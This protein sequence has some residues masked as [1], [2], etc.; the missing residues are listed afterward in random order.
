M[1]K[2]PSM[3]ML[4]GIYRREPAALAAAERME[5]IQADDPNAVRMVGAEAGES[6]TWFRSAL[7]RRY[8]SSVGLGGAASSSWSPPAIGMDGAES[9]FDLTGNLSH[10]LWQSAVDCTK[11]EVQVE[12]RFEQ[13][14]EQR[15]LDQLRL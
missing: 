5:P 2:F 3:E 15:A 10:I 9:S 7:N 13:R 11:H 1:A 4:E 6:Q 12:Q 14:F 8:P